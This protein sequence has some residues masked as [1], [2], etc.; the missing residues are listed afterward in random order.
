MLVYHKFDKG[1]PRG[2]RYC[3]RR[4]KWG[5]PFVLARGAGD[6]ERRAVIAKYILYVDRALAA[7][8]LDLADLA[9]APAL[10]CWCAKHG[11]PLAASAEPDRCHAQYLAYLLERKDD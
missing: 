9:G 11:A 6:G 8:D 1:A 4:G 5:N 10:S 7:G 2:T 3:G